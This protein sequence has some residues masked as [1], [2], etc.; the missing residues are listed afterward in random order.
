MHWIH[1]DG[2][3]V[4]ARRGRDRGIANQVNGSRTSPPAPPKGENDNAQEAETEQ[5]R[6]EVQH[7]GE[8]GV[9]R[10]W[11]RGCLLGND[12]E[13][14]RKLEGDLRRTADGQ[15]LG[16]AAIEADELSADVATRR[17]DDGSLARRDWHREVVGRV[18]EPVICCAIRIV[19][20]VDRVESRYRVAAARS[21]HEAQGR[22]GQRGQGRKE[23]A[24]L[25]AGVRNLNGPARRL[26]G[27][28]DLPIRSKCAAPVGV[29]ASREWRP[30]PEEPRED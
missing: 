11:C 18:E 17:N 27:Q 9:G 23:V 29:Q 1:N 28:I 3:S 4:G 8:S 19:G 15:D 6:G 5:G 30:T 2:A 14:C 10:W 21:R 26:E 22:S 7:A 25:R 16:C 13:L 24:R 12:G 20:L